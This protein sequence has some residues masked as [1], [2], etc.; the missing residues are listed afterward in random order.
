MKRN[1]LCYVQWHVICEK[2][3]WIKM[4]IVLAV[5]V[6]NACVVVKMVLAL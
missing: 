1:T 3:N 2:A 4:H 6:R 5:D